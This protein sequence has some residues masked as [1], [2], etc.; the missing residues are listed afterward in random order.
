VGAC[1]GFVGAGYVGG[2]WFDFSGFSFMCGLVAFAASFFSA[3]NQNMLSFALSSVPWRRAKSRRSHCEKKY[4][5]P[6]GPS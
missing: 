6:K 2:Q 4:S 1:S 3:F 5:E